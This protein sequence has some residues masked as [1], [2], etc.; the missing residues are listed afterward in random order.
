MV[1]Y[2]FICEVRLI[3][4]YVKK[5]NL[6]TADDETERIEILIVFG[7]GDQQHSHPLSFASAISYF[8]FSKVKD[9]KINVN[10]Q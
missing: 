8:E 9:D 7:D 5:V 6:I 10:G 2:S 3:F 1:F 4:Q